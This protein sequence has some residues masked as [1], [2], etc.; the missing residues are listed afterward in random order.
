MSQLMAFLFTMSLILVACEPA[1]APIST[2]MPSRVST[3]SPTSPPTVIPPSTSS[4]TKTSAEGIAHQTDPGAHV[5]SLGGNGWAL[6]IGERMLVFDYV[7]RS[8]PNP[9][10]PGEARN[11]QSGYVDPDELRAFDT[12]VFVTHSHQDHYD[13][14]ILGWER[15]VDK[16]TYF[17]GWKAGNNPEHHYMV[18]PRAHM[19]AGGVEVYTINSH[20]AGVPEVAFLVKVDGFTI[21]H[22]GDYRAE[23]QKD[24]E[25]LRTIAD[26]IDIA[27]VMGHPYV[28][29]QYFQQAVLLAEMF[30][31]TYMFAI[32]REGDE[33]RSRQFAELLAERGVKAHV[34]YAKQRGDDFICPKSTAE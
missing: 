20:H 12:Y 18:G 27:F 29:H 4:P 19:Q 17:F 5:W 7:G 6:R 10:A 26:R 1:N 28:N 25:Y 34:V 15:Q 32:N 30:H 13:P 3:V 14:A 11:L 9:P 8:G 2:G 31:P 22:N 24:F 16:I 23:Y 21:Y 33:D